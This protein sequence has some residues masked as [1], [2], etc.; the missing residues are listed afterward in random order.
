MRTYI[1]C[2]A[3]MLLPACFGQVARSPQRPPSDM[4]QMD[5]KQAIV[6]AIALDSINQRRAAGKSVREAALEVAVVRLR[7]ASINPCRS[8]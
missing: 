3:V 1:F 7:S 2:L 6:E 5:V 4:E 8:R